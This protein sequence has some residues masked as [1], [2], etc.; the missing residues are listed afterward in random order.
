MKTIIN[1]FKYFVSIFLL[2]LVLDEHG[3]N[4]FK[5]IQ[6]IEYKYLLLIILLSTLQYL[7]SAY[8]WVY[9]SKF[10]NMNLSYSYSLKFYYISSFLNNIL[11]GGIVGDIYRIYHSSEKKAFFE[12][13][14]S[15]QSVFF[16]RL[17]GQLVL[18]V[19]FII[20]LT[21]YFF[22][23]QKYVAFMYLFFLILISTLILKIFF[24]K[25]IKNFFSNNIIGQNFYRIFSGHIFWNHIF[26]SFL[27]VITYIL[28]YIISALSLNLTID[29]FAFFVFSPIILFSMTIPISIGGWG[30]REG[31]ALLVS[32]LLG[33]SAS[34]SISVS[35][36]YGLLN[37]ICSFPGLF[38]ILISSKKPKI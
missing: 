27:V 4:I 14:K 18:F 8:R 15:F 31:T 37:L 34:A 10:S 26:Y 30:V 7:I 29:Y 20:S 13:G 21:I 6:L 22:I 38:L 23:N 25:K 3:K 36:I 11:P 1:I 19:T 12:I 35:I 16:E 33:L 32:F 24:G 5:I 28:I 2:Y 17:S 9:I